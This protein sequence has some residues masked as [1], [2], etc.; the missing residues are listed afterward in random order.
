[1]RALAVLKRAGWGSRIS[2]TPPPTAAVRN[3]TGAPVA[4]VEPKGSPTLL[5]EKGSPFSR[6]ASFATKHL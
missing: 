2:Q 6:R 4:Y 5:A 3:A 1:M